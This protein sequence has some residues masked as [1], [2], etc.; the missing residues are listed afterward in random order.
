MAG[1]PKAACGALED[2]VTRKPLVGLAHQYEKPPAG[3]RKG[4]VVVHGIGRQ[5]ESDALVEIAQPLLEWVLAW[6]RARDRAADLAYFAKHGSRAPWSWANVRHPQAYLANA[7]L[8][9]ATADDGFVA[10]EYPPHIT[11]HVDGDPAYGDAGTA[12]DWV[13]AEAWWAQS[14]RTAPLGVIS[15]WVL[16]HALALVVDFVRFLWDRLWWLVHPW[17]DKGGNKYRPIPHFLV[18]YIDFVNMAF[19]IALS[20]LLMVPVLAAAPI[21]LLL[22]QVPWKPVRDFALTV[23]LRSF[24][25]ANVAEMRALVEDLVQEANVRARI[26]ETV[27]WLVDRGCEDVY[28]IAH[29]AGAVASFDA[30]AHS[31]AWQDPS[32]CQRVGKFFSVG[33]GLNKAWL[34]ASDQFRLQG[35]IRD[36][37]WADFWATY[38]PVPLG[39]LLPPLEP[40]PPS[41]AEGRPRLLAWA[42]DRMSDLGSF[43]SGRGTRWWIFVP[44]KG[45]ALETRVKAQG[46]LV[47]ENGRPVDL[48]VTNWMDFATAH[49]G[50]WANDEEVIS[51]I[52]QEIDELAF[53]SSRFWWQRGNRAWQEQRQGLWVQR[54]M[55][56]MAAL[57]V[58]RLCVYVLL[59]ASLAARW[60]DLDG[61]GH[62]AWNMLRQLPGVSGLTDTLGTVNHAIH[63]AAP[64]GWILAVKVWVHTHVPLLLGAVLKEWPF[65]AVGGLLVGLLF[66]V[67]YQLGATLVWDGWDVAQRRDFLRELAEL[68]ERS[69]P[70][71]IRSVLVVAGFV[72]WLGFMVIVAGQRFGQQGAPHWSS[73]LSGLAGLTPPLIRDN[74]VW[75][76]SLWGLIGLILLGGILWI[77]HHGLD[78]LFPVKDDERQTPNPGEPPAWRTRLVQDDGSTVTAQRDPLP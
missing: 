60:Q 8:A 55:W 43:V 2:V 52:A 75:A 45:S 37:Y 63:V 16:K 74:A 21:L 25:T 26:E 18:R 19:V 28:V 40:A 9:F 59:A 34:L 23:A 29:S 14:Y 24:L 70:P 65:Q 11:L 15:G 53:E 77:V 20:C 36:V 66:F 10:H 69:R 49:G 56:R 47:T 51:R 1:R 35:R 72:V 58:A 78:R 38:D 31:E 64:A 6:A 62:G 67:A 71:I 32:L 46:T 42:G 76:Y 4:I 30:L 27:A 12:L 48:R 54:R 57:V 13:V 33:A 7:G 41:T 68:P 50:Y 3:K 44:P 39:P 73:T 17:K 22:T 5:K 61:Y